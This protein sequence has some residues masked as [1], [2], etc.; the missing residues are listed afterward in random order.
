MQLAAFHHFVVD[1]AFISFRYAAHL[2]QGHGPVFN[3]GE[4]VEGYSN[5]LWVAVLALAAVLGLDI[6][7]ASKLLGLFS[8]L[9]TIWLSYKLAL[10]LSSAGSP[11][12]LAL[13]LLLASTFPI[14]YFGITGMETVAF[15]C[16]LLAAV[17]L[18][19]AADN[20]LT[21]TATLCLFAGS[22]MRPEGI[23]Y[24]PVLTL[25]D[26]LL[27]RRI[28]RRAGL[29]VV[30]FAALYAAFLLWRHSYYGEWLPNTFFAKPP[31]ASADFPPVVS[32]FDDLYR[33][34][35]ANFGILFLLLAGLPLLAGPRK[36]KATPL[37]S[38]CLVGVGFL[39][40]SG[41]DWMGSY[42]YLVP[43]L[44]LYLVLGVAGF[45][46]STEAVA[47]HHGPAAAI[48]RS[49]LV[50][51]GVFAIL[52]VFRVVEGG[53]FYIQRSHYPNFIMTSVDLIPAAQW[54]RARYPRN[55]TITCWRIGALAYYSELNLIDDGFG[56]TDKF[57]G[58][59]RYKGGYT[60]Q[61]HD[62]YIRERNPE[63]VMTGTSKH[64]TPESSATFGGRE[65][66]FVR[67][68]KQGDQQWWLLY[69]R[70]SAREGNL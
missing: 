61:V 15:S 31:K 48:L 5:P 6:V 50:I 69:E 35:S 44:P 30:L 45:E 3:L 57:V 70:C 7:L 11:Y 13:V 67:R 1:D 47:S 23:L 33:F 49:R 16:L 66:R 19:V 14:V 37:G 20:N 10:R 38:I 53:A 56:L 18:F 4:R 63:L 40:Y 55:Y 17:Y 64:V 54:I 36:L 52:G 46:M 28:T 34:L 25:V 65:Y 43:I 21:L 29:L 39:L 42:R 51:A 24:F 41:G 68:F 58:R 22:L 12:P 9:A 32:S 8:I 60:P 26:I 27:H 62:A 2:A 59:M